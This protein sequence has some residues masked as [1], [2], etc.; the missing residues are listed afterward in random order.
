VEELETL[1]NNSPFLAD[2]IE[3]VHNLIAVLSARQR[4]EQD[5]DQDDQELIMK[6][7]QMYQQQLEELRKQGQQEG[8]Q[9]GLQEGQQEG[10]RT[11]VERERRAIIESIL[12]V[13]FGEVDAELTRIINPLMAM[14]RE[15]FTPLLLQ[16]SREELLARFSAQ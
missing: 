8:R 7:S 11:G 6:L 15:E 13:R 4:Q 5:I 3:L 9:E 14:S 1:T 12:Q 16:S 2:V 10:L